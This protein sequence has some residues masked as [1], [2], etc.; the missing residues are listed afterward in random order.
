MAARLHKWKQREKHCNLKIQ[1]GSYSRVLLNILANRGITEKGK[2]ESFL[3]PTVYDLHSPKLLPNMGPATERLIEAINHKQKILIFGDYDAD[4]VISLCLMYNF[5]KDLGLKPDTYIPNRFDEGYDISLDFIKGA[6]KYSLVICVDCGTNSLQVKEFVNFCTDYPDIIACDHHEPVDKQDVGITEKYIIVNPKLGKSRY[7]F[8]GL[9]GA[10]VTFKFIVNILRELNQEKKEDFSSG[11]L[12]GLLDM[13]AISTI[14][15][16][17]PLVDENRVIVKKGLQIMEKTSNRGLGCLLETTLGKQKNINTYDIG[18]VI[19][20]RI[21]SAGRLETARESADIFKSDSRNIEQKVERLNSFNQE[22]RKIQE[23]IL[24]SILEREGLE[25]TIL[26]QKV[27]VAKSKTWNEGVLGIVASDMVKRFNVPVI[28]FAE[29]GDTLK[30]SGRSIERFNLYRN[31]LHLSSYFDKFGGH[32]MAC[33]I[34]MDAAKYENFKKDLIGLACRL[35]GD[36]A[37]TKV[38]SYDME[39]GFNLISKELI[40]ELKVLEPHGVANP[41][42]VFR[43]DNCEVKNICCLKGGRHVKLMLQESERLMEAV[44]FNTEQQI[45]DVL[46]KKDKIN[47]LYSLQENNWNGISSIQLVLVDLF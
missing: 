30:G 15:D 38:I 43:T 12:T 23:A 8:K 5:L 7:P 31:L 32:E 17:M 14:A 10:G 28:L 6:K 37:L 2:I 4:G 33:G 45:K 13:V 35:Q 22:R 24:K 34:T 47:I 36:E 27:F 40:K 16:V 1:A 19:A 11:Y 41:R 25:K 42:P 26:N 21:N 44:Y 46:D 9:S 18:F 20:P 39:I 29:K 3:N